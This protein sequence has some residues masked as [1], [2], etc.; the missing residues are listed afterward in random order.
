MTE[1]PEPEP[2]RPVDV[3]GVAI[4]S[5]GTGLWAVALVLSVVFEGHL[6]RHGQRWWIAAAACGFGL[7]LLGIGYC[8]RRRS[9]LREGVL[10][11]ETR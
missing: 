10:D 11:Q 8:V 5:L 3:D 6:R 4:V 9:R 2:L 1:E 7:G